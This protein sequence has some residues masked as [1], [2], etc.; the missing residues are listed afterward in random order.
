M[1]LWKKYK[2][3]F[4]KKRDIKLF[5]SH[6]TINLKIVGQKNFKKLIQISQI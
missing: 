1:A 4:I 6:H 3:L 2:I 5:V